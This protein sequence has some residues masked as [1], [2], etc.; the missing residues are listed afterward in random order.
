[1]YI[2]TSRAET[3]FTRSPDHCITV[4]VH[5]VWLSQDIVTLP[6]FIRLS[7][8]LHLSQDDGLRIISNT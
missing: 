4:V 1:M 6:A 8:N 2:H 7:K 5:A 3:L